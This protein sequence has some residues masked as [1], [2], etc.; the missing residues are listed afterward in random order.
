MNYLNFNLRP[1]SDTEIDHFIKM[2]GLIVQQHLLVRE[3]SPANSGVS[4]VPTKDNL[5]ES[6][7][8]SIGKLEK[9]ILFKV[10]KEY[11]EKNSDDMDCQ[12]PED[13]GSESTSNSENDASC[14][15]L[16]G[17][18]TLSERSRRI[19]KYKKKI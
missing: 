1:L 15:K 5:S 12:D 7:Q 16:V 2:N 4:E 14:S 11:M 8:K 3:N 6:H 13:M 17:N 18:Y 19:L 9:E 10:P